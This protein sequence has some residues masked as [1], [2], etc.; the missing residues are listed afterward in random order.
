VNTF[1]IL[2]DFTPLV[3]SNSGLWTENT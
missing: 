3:A 1:V 2:T